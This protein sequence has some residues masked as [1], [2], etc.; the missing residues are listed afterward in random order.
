MN[1]LCCDRPQ[2]VIRTELVRVALAV[3]ALDGPPRSV[4]TVSIR[5]ET[6]IDEAL[7]HL[8]NKKIDAA[9]EPGKKLV[10]GAVL[11]LEFEWNG[12]VRDKSPGGA[13]NPL[14]EQHAAGSIRRVMHG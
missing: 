6:G 3:V 2:T 10:I 9:E 11:W 7:V 4:I 13:L 14:F 5:L 1:F 8:M 12:W